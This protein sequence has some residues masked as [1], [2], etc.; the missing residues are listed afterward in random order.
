[1]CLKIK[2]D[3]Y[4][5]KHAYKKNVLFYSYLSFNSLVLIFIRFNIIKSNLN[6]SRING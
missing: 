4:N 3:I 1:M 5:N 2:A 6:I